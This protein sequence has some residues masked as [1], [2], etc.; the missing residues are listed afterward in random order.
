MDAD[1]DFSEAAMRAEIE[2]DL[3]DGVTLVHAKAEREELLTKVNVRFAF[4]HVDKLKEI[5]LDADDAEDGGAPVDS[6]PFE[7]LEIIEE[8][9]QIIIRSQPIN[10]VEEMA[11]LDEMPF[12]SDEMVEKLLRGLRRHL[13]AHV[14]LQ[15]GRAQRHPEE[16]QHARVGVQPRD[17]EIGR[18]EGHLRSPETLTDWS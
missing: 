9:D 1:E 6:E 14:A 8:G 7:D 16:G 12:V 17:P 2:P 4:D 13:H 5:H 18:S 3:P 11:E 15:G 10:P